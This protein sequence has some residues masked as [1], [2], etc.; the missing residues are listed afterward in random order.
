[1]KD[2]TV[3]ISFELLNALFDPGLITVATIPPPFNQK[4][5]G[6]FQAGDHFKITTCYRIPAALE[7]GDTWLK[8]ATAD[9]YTTEHGERFAEKPIFWI[10]IDE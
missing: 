2:T 6:V 8:I 10:K 3:T 9:V 7:S 4:N 5:L 1:M